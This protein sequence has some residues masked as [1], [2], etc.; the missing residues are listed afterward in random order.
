MCNAKSKS[1]L[2]CDDL[3]C[4]LTGPLGMS[5]RQIRRINQLINHAIITF[6]GC[7]P[8]ASHPVNTVLHAAKYCAVTRKPLCWQATGWNTNFTLS[9]SYS[10]HKSSYHMFFKPIQIP[11]ALNTGT[12]IRQGDLFYSAGLHRNHVLA[13]DNTGKIRRGFGKMQVNGLEG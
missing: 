12:C 5:G 10:F 6:V 8:W 3:C 11:W 4:S 1:D 9:P 7:L 13:T 2:W